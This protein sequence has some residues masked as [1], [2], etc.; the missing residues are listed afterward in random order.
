[1]TYVLISAGLLAISVLSGVLMNFKS[2]WII[3]NHFKIVA[4]NMSVLLTFTVIELIPLAVDFSH[5]GLIFI[6]LGILIPLLFHHNGHKHE[7]EQKSK[8]SIKF[9]MMGACIHS[10][11]DGMI[12]AT[13]FLV[14]EHTGIVIISSMLLHKLTEII[15]FSLIL[16]TLVRDSFRLIIY[17]V[18]LSFC[19][20]L[21]MMVT[22]GFIGR[23]ENIETI[24][25]IAI[26]LSAGIFIFM[27]LTALS[28]VV[29]CSN[30]KY[31]NFYPFVGCALYFGL[32]IF[33][34]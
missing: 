13:G 29:E 10:F 28:K 14:D 33:L 16:C 2:Q 8:L 27:A 26:S 30:L 3:H 12:I 4:L 9:M 11:V 18:S 23:L 24:S 22:A 31:A 17:L 25:G 7:E 15:M 19:T 34:H 20:I 5:V 6:V 21:G 32:H 1:M